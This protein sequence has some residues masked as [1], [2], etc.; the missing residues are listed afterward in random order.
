MK[1]NY[2]THTTWCDGRNTPREMAEAAA[3]KG[4][5]ELG[6]SSHSMLPQDDV[7]WVLTP[8]KALRYAAEV[9]SLA[10]EWRGR[11]RILCGVEADYVPGCAEPSRAAYAAVS[12]DYMIGS[13]HFVRAADGS[14]VPTDHTPP[15]LADGIR[16]HFGGD[17]AVFVRS[18]FAAVRE[19]LAFDFDVV[20]HPDLVRKFNAKHPY[21][22]EAAGWYREELERT[23]DAIAASGKLVE[24]NT[25][26]ISR[27][28][29]DD[30]YPSPTFRSLLRARGVRFVLSSDAHSAEGLDCA[31]DRF[32]T[33]ERYER[34]A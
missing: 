30:A 6:F 23:A 15:Q 3:A 21:F 12:P 9:R 22:D 5:A 25:G 34:P 24:V 14:L 7:D 8:E 29:L 11:M 13:V 4:F 31:F 28:W 27:G 1:A 33:A 26:A 19:S 20:G 10:D 18:Y 16:D 17:P 32:G 2:H